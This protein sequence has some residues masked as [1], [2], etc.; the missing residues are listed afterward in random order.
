MLSLP[1]SLC[2]RIP[3]VMEGLAPGSLSMVVPGNTEFG[4][5]LGIVWPTC[6]GIASVPT[7]TPSCTNQF[8]LRASVPQLKREWSPGP[9]FGSI[10]GRSPGALR[11]S[12][13]QPR[14]QVST[15]QRAGST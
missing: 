9:K 2:Q 10:A 13:A 4:K 8:L 1:L 3:A 7:V 14:S 6:H 11:I 12:H 5:G 15:S